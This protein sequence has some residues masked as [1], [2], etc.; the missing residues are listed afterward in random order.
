MKF[1]LRLLYICR[2]NHNHADMLCFLQI[3]LSYSPKR[4]IQRLDQIFHFL[5]PDG[6]ADR[7]LFDSL[8]QR[9]FFGRLAM[10]RR[11]GMYY[12]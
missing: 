7:I 10:C 9:L 6:K 8:I 5:D 3:N 11:C 12:K 2:I 1:I 4:S